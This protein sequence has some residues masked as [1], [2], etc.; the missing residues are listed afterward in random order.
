MINIHSFTFNPF[1]ENTYLLTNEQKEALIIDPGMYGNAEALQMINFIEKNNYQLIK[2]INT[3]AHIDHILGVDDL[4]TKFNIPFAL[5]ADEET[6]LELGTLSAATYGLNFKIA[7]LVDEYLE[8]GQIIE[9][10]DSQIQCLLTPGHSPG[11]LSFYLPKEKILIAGDT[12]FNG[13]IGR[14][15]LPGGHHDTLIQSIQNQLYTLPDDTMV[16]PGHGPVTQI[17]HEKKSNPF[18]QA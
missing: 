12:L 1:Q 8:E 3:H 10:G 16:Y 13:S 5:H 11:S 2:I 14:T 15:D 7:P 4:K 9:F 17:G 18:V 6:V